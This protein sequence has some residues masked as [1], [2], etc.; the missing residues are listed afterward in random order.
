MIDFNELIENH[1]KREL[2]PKD[3]GRYYPSEIGS[4]IRKTWYSYKFPVETTTEKLKIF[5]MG[6]LLHHFIAQVLSSEK[7]T[8]IQLLETELP[9]K[10][11]FKDINVSG[12]IDNLLIVKETSRKI[13]V[14][15]KSTKSINSLIEAQPH[16]LM[17][18]Q[19]YMHYL[20]VPDGA[21]VYIEKN[22]LRAKTFEVKH[23]ETIV[24]EALFRFQRLH[25]MLKTDV[26]PEA[27][28]RMNTDMSWMCKHCEYR[29][30]CFK[31]TPHL[32]GS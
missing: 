31:D 13:L 18:L 6:N 1:V 17:Q 30:K 28:A 11:Q 12:R 27:E 15:I 14:E 19:L 4:C 3:I 8:H 22:T 21:L 25:E 24:A 32:N 2:K 16:H 26:I 7:N 10:M 20:N 23:D 29:E 9:F 5:E